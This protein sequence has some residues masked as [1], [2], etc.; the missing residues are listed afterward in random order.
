MAISMLA[1]LQI[2]AA[3]SKASMLLNLVRGS[4]GQR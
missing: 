4:V 1:S 2:E 3:V